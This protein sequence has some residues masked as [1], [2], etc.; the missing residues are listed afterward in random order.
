MKVIFI[1][2][3]KVKPQAKK[4]YL[5]AIKLI[6]AKMSEVMQNYDVY[7]QKN[8]DTYYEIYIFDSYEE[9]DSMDENITDNIKILIDSLKHYID[10]E[11]S[12]QTL[13]QLED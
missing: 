3:Y 8:K 9:F 1:V 7:E 5:K 10:G 11:I 13:I 2:S 6:R 12:Y 4:D